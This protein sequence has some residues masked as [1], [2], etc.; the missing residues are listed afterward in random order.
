[1][2]NVRY[3]RTSPYKYQSI[4]EMLIYE[5]ALTAA[6]VFVLR[7][8]TYVDQ[9]RFSLSD[10]EMSSDMIKSCSLPLGILA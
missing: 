7:N 6:V 3:I 2:Q 8:R 5:E 9:A 10:S 1:M 4:K